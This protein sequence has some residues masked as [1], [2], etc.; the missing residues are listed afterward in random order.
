M[1]QSLK[2]KGLFVFSDPGGA[3]AIL[4]LVLSIKRNLTDFLIVSDRSYDFFKE[5]GLQ[6][7]PAENTPLEIIETF[8]PDF[9]LA[10]TSYTSKIELTYIIE[11]NQLNIQNFSF[12]D[13]WTSFKQR[14]LIND[15][16]IVP[17]KILLI[18]ALAKKLCLEEGFSEAQVEVIGNPYY[19]YLK[20][21]KPLHEKDDFFENTFGKSFEGQKILTYVPEP[22]SN[23][24]GVDKFGFDEI[25]V[26]ECFVSSLKSFS[27]ENKQ[28]IRLLIKPHPNQNKP[29]LLKAIEQAIINEP[30]ISINF[31][32]NVNIND[33][34]FHSD[35]VIGM[36][37]NSLIEAHFLQ[38]KVIRLMPDSKTTDPLISILPN[39]I[40]ETDNEVYR[41]ILSVLL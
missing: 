35:I 11:A 12:V 13:H 2:G 3:K 6:V 23:V 4:A 28:K 36:F 30:L 1:I 32:E 19:E 10:G 40:C 16:L 34:M 37:S 33:L 14:F 17:S 7:V 24:G 21:W 31:I 26:F 18:D 22:L 20:I 15:N 25:S 27:N 29:L 38:K 5:F 8:K 39:T 9:V 41:C